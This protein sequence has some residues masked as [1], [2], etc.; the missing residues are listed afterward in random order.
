MAAVTSREKTLY[1]NGDWSRRS[2]SQCLLGCLKWPPSS[3]YLGHL[4]FVNLD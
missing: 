3:V 2:H 4:V 1:N